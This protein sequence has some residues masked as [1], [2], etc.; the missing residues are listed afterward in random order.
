MQRSEFITGCLKR[1]AEQFVIPPARKLH[2]PVMDYALGSK[3]S[4]ELRVLL[5][6]APP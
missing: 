4:C 1:T 5:R 3:L 6:R 2:S